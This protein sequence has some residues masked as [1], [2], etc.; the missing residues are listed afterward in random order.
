[1]YFQQS[2]HNP[3]HVHAVYD[4]HVAEIDIRTSKILHGYLPP[5]AMSIVCEWISIH[6]EELLEMWNTQEFRKI[7]PL[8]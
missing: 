8:E 4:D 7:D 2:E 6:N 1:M 3:L 5:K